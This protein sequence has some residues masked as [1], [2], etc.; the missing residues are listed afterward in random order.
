MFRLL[1]IVVFASLVACSPAKNGWD[2][3][4]QPIGVATEAI[5]S[6]RLPILRVVRDSVG[7][8]FYDDREA[9]GQPVVLT[10]S[11]LLQLDPELSS[12]KDL[13]MGWEAERRSP[14]QAWQ[15]RRLVSN[16]SR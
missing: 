13:E 3:P 1:S 10:K 4:L 9:P 8:Q 6:G 14:K 11:A 7:W 16:G 15:R 12:L 2:D 5:A